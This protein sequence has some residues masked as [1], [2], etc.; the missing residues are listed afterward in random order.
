M[1]ELL[2]FYAASDVAFVGGSLVPV[3][4]HNMLEP[5]SLGVP[6]VVGPH[7]HNFEE[8]SEALFEVGGARRVR[9]REELESAVS[10]LLSDAGAREGMAEN[11]SRLIEANRGASQRLL[12]IVDE[13]LGASRRGVVAAPGAAAVRES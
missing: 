2:L 7:L 11:G 4:G 9:D 1:G 5:V 12:D 13:M 8:L 3:G 10:E 6:V